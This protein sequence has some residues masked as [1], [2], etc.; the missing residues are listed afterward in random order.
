MTDGANRPLWLGERTLNA[1]SG[2][3]HGSLDCTRSR[4]GPSFL[5]HA[6]TDSH[7]FALDA[8]QIFNRK[9]RSAPTFCGLTG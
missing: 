5:T 7:V 3:D 1:L 6:S 8:Q 9:R 2:S 4:L